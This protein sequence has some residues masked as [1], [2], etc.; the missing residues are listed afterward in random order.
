MAEKQ[1]PKVEKDSREYTIPLRE[2]CRPVPI[3]RKTPRAVKTVKQFLAR[4]MKVY[5]RDLNKIKLDKYLNE[6]L[7]FRGIKNPPHKVKVRV[8]KEENLIK[9]E[10]AE[11]PKKLEFKKARAE[12]QE[13]KSQ[14]KAKAVAPKLNKEETPGKDGAKDKVE[15]KKENPPKEGIVDKDKDGVDDK[16]E[17]KEK[18]KAV[19]EEG[20]KIEKAHKKKKDNTT[21]PQ[22]PTKQ[23]QEETTRDASH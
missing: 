16:V 9:V 8:T 23:R 19:E 1:T 20:N 4:H 12:K 6:F 7:W 11:L 10:L 22:T 13:K 18:A 21:T 15:K 17:E 2:K 3:Y 14:E 5:D